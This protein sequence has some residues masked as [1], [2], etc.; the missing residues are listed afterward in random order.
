MPI[1]A[2]TQDK[3][4]WYWKQDFIESCWDPPCVGAIILNV[5]KLILTKTWH[6]D[7]LNEKAENDCACD[8]YR[9]RSLIITYL[10]LASINIAHVIFLLANKMF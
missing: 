4:L 7:D 5:Q 6:N 3:S 2:E 9:K 10:F 8:C 1:R